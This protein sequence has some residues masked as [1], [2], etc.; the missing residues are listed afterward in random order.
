MHGGLFW[1]DMTLA[2]YCA[3][4]DSRISWQEGLAIE[5]TIRQARNGAHPKPENRAA[6]AMGYAIAHH[7]QRKRPLKCALDDFSVCAHG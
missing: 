7:F 6:Q 2:D 4:W 3:Y 5:E 1:K